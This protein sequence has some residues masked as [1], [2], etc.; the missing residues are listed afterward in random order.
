M[1]LKEFMEKVIWGNTIQDY[2]WAVVIIIMGLVII[3]FMQTMV[4]RK[5]LKWTQ[6]RDGE[7]EQ[8]LLKIIHKQLPVLMY[9][10]LFYIVTQVLY[11]NVHVIRLIN[12]MLLICITYITAVIASAIVEF[13]L[14]GYAVKMHSDTNKQL[15]IHWVYKIAK[16]LIWMIAVIL[17]L[18]NLGIKI[19]ALVAGLGVGGIAIAF[20][21]QAILEDI[22]SYFTIFLDRPFEIGDF[23]NVAEYAGTVE[24]IGLRTTRVLSISGEQLIF[25]NKDLTNSRVKN[26]KAMERR[27]ILFQLGITYDTSMEQLKNI[28]SMVQRIIEGQENVTF[29]RAHFTSYGESS[30]KFEFV[31]Y[32]MTSDYYIYMDVQ[33]SINYQ[34]KETF[35]EKGIEFAFPTR[36]LYTHNVNA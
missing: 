23:I 32:V 21:A 24:H 34:I 12:L 15:A 11:L 8:K 9:M 5:I 27:R 16:T 20:A 28:P 31:Y 17:F 19:G 3:N 22:F 7:T 18:Q 35:D 13:L 36:T 26:F 25:P 4:F 14:V 33:Q 10:G 2:L 30:L 6:R 29:D 1:I